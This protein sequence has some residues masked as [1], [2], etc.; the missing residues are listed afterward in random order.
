MLAA[1]RQFV[2]AIV[3][4]AAFSRFRHAQY[5]SGRGRHRAGVPPEIGLAEGDRILSVAG[6]ETAAFEDLQRIVS[7]RPNAKVIIRFSRGGE[8][9]QIEAR[10]AMVEEKDESGSDIRSAVSV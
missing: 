10:L 1:H 6:Q 3:I 5:S 2:L 9:R 8:I 4:F 7:I